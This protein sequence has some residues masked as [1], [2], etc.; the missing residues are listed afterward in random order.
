MQ[1][2]LMMLEAL[3]RTTCLTHLYSISLLRDTRKT[4]RVK[5]QQYTL[6]SS[7]AKIRSQRRNTTLSRPPTLKIGTSIAAI[8]TNNAWSKSALCH[9]KLPLPQV[10]DKWTL[11]VQGNSIS[12]CWMINFRKMSLRK[13]VRTMKQRSSHSTDRSNNKRDH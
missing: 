2:R 12:A 8:R 9:H 3:F 10:R 7:A 5:F 1:D 6:V 11:W 4:S 13:R